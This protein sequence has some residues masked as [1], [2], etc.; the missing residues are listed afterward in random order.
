MSQARLVIS[1]MK[2]APL[3]LL[4]LDAGLHH[5]GDR[6]AAPGKCTC[7]HRDV[8]TITVDYHHL[9]FWLAVNAGEMHQ[10]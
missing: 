5:N 3:G 2:F 1:H 7:S 8:V 4:W 10:H 9:A 6:I